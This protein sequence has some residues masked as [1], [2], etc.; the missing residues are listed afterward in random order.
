MNAKAAVVAKVNKAAE[1]RKALKE[2]G[3]NAG[4]KDVIAHL[5]KQGI[6]V[7][8]AQISN[9][10][11]DENGGSTKRRKQTEVVITNDDLV[12]AKDYA[13]S[14]GT[15]AALDVTNTFIALQLGNSDLVGDEH[16]ALNYPTDALFLAKK[17]VA[18]V[19]V[20]KAPLLLQALNA[21]QVDNKS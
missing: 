9:I 15:I 3:K 13:V 11:A 1:I 21:L 4:N 5:A 2:L 6:E 14:V 17:F 16:L 18:T 12:T 7:A 19:G 20:E 8:S 10:K